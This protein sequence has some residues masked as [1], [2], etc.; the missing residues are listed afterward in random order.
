MFEIVQNIIIKHL[1]V[2]KEDITLDTRLFEIGSDSLDGF[3]IIILLENEF[4]ISIEDPNK[5]TTIR[6]LINYIEKSTK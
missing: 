2:D 4:N 6:D 5:N 1:K 3:E